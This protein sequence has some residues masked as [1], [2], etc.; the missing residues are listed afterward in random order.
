M[1]LAKAV[2]HLQ[3]KQKILFLTTSNRWPGDKEKPKSTLLAERIAAAV[4]LEKVTILDIP[5]LIIYNCEGNISRGKG[6]NC[7]VKAAL[8]QS[9]EKNPSNLHR[10]WA[11]FNNK[12]DELWKISKELFQSDC[13]V[14]F[15]S[16]RWGQMNAYYQKLIE[17]L[18]WLENRHSTLQEENILKNID[19]GLII[20]GQNWNGKNVVETQKKVLQFFGF[21]VVDALCWNWQFTNNTKDESQK[22]YQAAL[23]TF[24]QEILSK[25]K[26]EN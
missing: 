24:K 21:K 12:D 6:N 9:K 11:S 3:Q 23:P 19:A 8:L 10:C 17:R 2:K 4:G 16:V 14:F 1:V 15:G 20:V 25:I 18:S 7:G 5:K 22:S 13:V 26:K